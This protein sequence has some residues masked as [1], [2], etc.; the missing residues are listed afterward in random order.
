MHTHKQHATSKEAN[1]TCRRDAQPHHSFFGNYDYGT[2]KPF[3]SSRQAHENL[4]DLPSGPGTVS[5]KMN[6]THLC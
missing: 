3:P 2:L 1:P 5:K 6:L 4:K